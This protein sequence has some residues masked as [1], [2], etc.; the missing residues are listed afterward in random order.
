[1]AEISTLSKTRGIISLYDGKKYI[2]W[3][4]VYGIVA[5]SNTIKRYREDNGG[6][7]EVNIFFD[8]CDWCG[9]WDL[10]SI[11]RR[12]IKKLECR[13]IEK[14]VKIEFNVVGD[15]GM[16]YLKRALKFESEAY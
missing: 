15:M 2:I 12:G 3:S 1:M 6:E 5:E 10:R 14:D 4:E 8:I 7:K 11:I 16:C 13:Y 9:C